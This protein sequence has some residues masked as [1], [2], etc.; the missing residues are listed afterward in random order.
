ME[1]VVC[2]RAVLGPRPAAREEP[3]V[4]E[5]VEVVAVADAEVSDLHNSLI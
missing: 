3:A 2:L 5:I 1:P 4:E